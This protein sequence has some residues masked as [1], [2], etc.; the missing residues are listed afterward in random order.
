MVKPWWFCQEFVR[1]DSYSF[2]PLTS[3][4]RCIVVLCLFC[5]LKPVKRRQQRSLNKYDGFLLQSWMVEWAIL[6]KSSW[7]TRCKHGIR[8]AYPCRGNI[9]LPWGS[10]LIWFEGPELHNHLLENE[11]L[12]NLKLSNA[13]KVYQGQDVI[14]F[15][16]LKEV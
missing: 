2:S 11:L 12:I 9:Y 16:K 8:V 15:I 5:E 7:Q 1:E 13:R 14:E 4:E 3:L 10:N 6:E